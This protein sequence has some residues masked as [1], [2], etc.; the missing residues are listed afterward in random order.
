MKETLNIFVVNS[1]KTSW[2]A[3]IWI[4]FVQE[5]RQKVQTL[6]NWHVGVIEGQPLLV[7][8][9]IVGLEK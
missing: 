2:K 3:Y 6:E 1:R 7:L 4:R 8:E 9:Q 5:A